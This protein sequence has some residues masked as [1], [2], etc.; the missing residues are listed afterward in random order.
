MTDFELVLVLLS[1]HVLLCIRDLCVRHHWLVLI[2]SIRK[3]LRRLHLRGNFQLLRYTAIK[4]RYPCG[5]RVIQFDAIW[6]ICIPFVDCRKRRI[7]ICVVPLTYSSDKDLGSTSY[8]SSPPVQCGAILCTNWSYF[9][10]QYENYLQKSIEWF[11]TQLRFCLI[12]I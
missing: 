11:F 6:T 3:M 2:A 4:L 8:N 12:S 1:G 5:L 9:S 10:S 7:V